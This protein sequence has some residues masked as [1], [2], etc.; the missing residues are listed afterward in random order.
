VSSKQGCGAP[1]VTGYG[2]EVLAVAARGLRGVLEEIDD[3]AVDFT[4]HPGTRSRLEG[5]AMAVEVLA[6]GEQSPGPRP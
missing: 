1:D 4:A 6:G 2:G 3:P 5:A